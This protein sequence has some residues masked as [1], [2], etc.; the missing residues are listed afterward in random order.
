PPAPTSSSSADQRLAIPSVERRRAGR[1][2][3]DGA[4][5]VLRLDPDPPERA[6][7][8]DLVPDEVEPRRGRMLVGAVH[9]WMA[10]LVEDVQVARERLQ[11][12]AEAGC[13]DHRVDRDDASISEHGLAVL[14]PL[15]R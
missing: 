7:E 10:A 9:E 14:E 1:I 8:R 12:S 13:G 2:P 3:G 5:E 11:S 4:R 6:A 15:E